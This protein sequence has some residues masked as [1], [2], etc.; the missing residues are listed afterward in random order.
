MGLGISLLSALIPAR[1]ATRLS[2][3]AALRDQETVTVASASHAGGR[4]WNRAAKLGLGLLAAL[5][6]YLA[7]APPGA[8]TGY[9]TPWDWIM[10]VALWAVWITALALLAPALI[11]AGLRGARVP[12]RR[13]GGATGRWISDNLARAPGRV[14]L[15]ALTFAVGLMMTV[16]TAGFVAFGN[17]VLVGRLAEAALRRTSW[18][19]YPFNRVNGLAQISAFDVDAPGIAPE[20]LAAVREVAEGRA[21]VDATYMVVVPEI[22]SPMPNFP[23]IVVEDVDH[24]T[25]PENF[26]LIEEDWDRALPI[27]KETCGLLITPAVA[28]K[29]GVGVGDDLT[30][31]GREGPVTCT[32]AGIGAGGIAPIAVIGPGGAAA[33]VP[34]DKPPDSLSVHPKSNTDVIALEADLY[35]L[36][37]R[38]GDRAFI[39]KPNDELASITSTSDQLMVIFNGTMFLAVVAAALGA[40]NTMLMSVAER[41]RELGLLRAVGATRRQILVTVMGEGALMGL[42]GALLGIGAGVGMAML[43]PLGYGGVTFGLVELSLWRAAGEVIPSALRS[44]LPGLVAAPLLAALAAVPAVRRL[45][46]SNLGLGTL[47]RGR[48]GAGRLSHRWATLRLLAWRNLTQHPARTLL[49]VLAVAL[50]VAMMIAAEVTS[51]AILGALA[52]SEMAQTFLTGLLDQLDAM[53]TLIGVGITLVAGFLV[54]NAFAMSVTRRRRH[55]GALRSLGMRRAQVLRLVL[56]EALFVGGLGTLLG[57]IM[58]PLL[59]HGAIALMRALTEGLFVFAAAQVAPGAVFLAAILGVGVTLLSALIPAWRATRISP[60][61]ALRRGEDALRE[62]APGTEAR[63]AA[64]QVRRIAL[65]LLAVAAF[66]VIAP[67]TA[68]DSVTIPAPLDAVVTGAT[69]FTWLAGLALAAPVLVGGIA[70]AARQPLTWLWG[71]MGRLAADNLGRG[72]GRVVVTILTLAVGLTMIVSMTGLIHFMY[73]ELMLP[74]L[75]QS[76]QMGTWMIAPFDYMAGMSAYVSPDALSL[77]PELLAEMR[78]A[79]AGKGQVMPVH[80]VIVPELSFFGSS[81]FSFVLDAAA[82]R[83]AGDGLF[84]FTE[85]DWATAAPI[86]ASGCG[87][88]V[89]PMVADRNGVAVGESFEVTGVHGPVRCTV[90]GIGAPIVETSII[91]AEAGEAFGVGDPILVI[92]WPTRLGERGKI[93]AELETLLEK[94]PGVT[95]NDLDSMTELQI[96]MM[97]A[98]PTMFNALLLL[99]ILAAALGVINTTMMSVAERRQ[100][101]RLLRAVGATRRQTLRVITGEAALMG[102]IGGGLGLVAGAGVIVILARVYGGAAWGLP[103]LDRWGAAWRSLHPALINGLIGLVAAPVICAL[104]AWFPARRTGRIV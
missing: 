2:P 84:D 82:V 55:I 60:L 89:S 11:A 87:V 27:L 63:A 23:S 13:F 92:A 30:V 90:A 41:R 86:M 67:P 14:T 44:G 72:R 88:L 7:I 76:G 32:V 100:E 66:L 36:H 98:L 95:L 59:G 77:P 21:T 53:L 102:V 38:F 62:I 65:M 103:E 49:S 16:S 52:A 19:V 94:Y 43:M 56:V 57:L 78:T 35:A 81:Y 29:H 17:E 39:S 58:G 26:R 71:A 85:G 34:P 12:L 75:Q 20:V 97:E 42:A 70:R 61:A 47:D 25:Q 15:T 9:H 48:R 40:I 4:S 5:L 91:S 69:A 8:W 6:I 93:E 50:G 1:R 24:L 96:Q 73:F 80:F 18:Y 101:L 83:Q 31:T 74:N 51:G 54:F 28:A 37:E 68:W 99:A 79:L 104:A 46:F 3:L 22:S 10:V 33:F 64:R 45:H